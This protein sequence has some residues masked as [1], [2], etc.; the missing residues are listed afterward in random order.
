MEEQLAKFFAGEASDQERKDVLEWRNASYENAEQFILAKTGWLESAN[1]SDVNE[2]LLANIID[3]PEAKIVG[4]PSYFKYA[5][6]VILLGM[7]ASLWYLNIGG[8]DA[9]NQLVFNGTS[10]VLKDGSIVS[11]KE[12]STLEILEFTDKLRRVRVSGKAFFDVERDEKRPFEVV[13]NEATVRVL[14]TSF[15]VIG[16]DDFT[17]VSVESGL[18]SLAMNNSRNGMSLNLEKGEMGMVRKNTQGIVKRKILD[19]NFLAWKS[20]IISFEGMK[21]FDVIKTINDVYNVSISMNE[22][23]FNCKLT[24]QF[25]QKTL[26][27]VLRI[28]SVTFDWSYQINDNKVVITGEGC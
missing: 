22:E 6:A 1:I 9:K 15:Q 10:H 28:L 4:W 21:A 16:E 12:G 7:I 3:Q 2:N 25:N 17:E 5:A 24:A 14:G 26:D 19:K 8:I 13:T 20:G 23:L 18:V 11:L 27:E